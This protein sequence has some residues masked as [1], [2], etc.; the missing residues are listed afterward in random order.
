MEKRISLF[1]AILTLGFAQQIHAQDGSDNAD[2]SERW[3][4]FLP[5]NKE[6]AG[7]AELPLP[8]GIGITGYWQE[9]DLKPKSIGLGV[10]LDAT[11]SGLVLA[12]TITN[13]QRDG[14]ET[15]IGGGTPTSTVNTT[16]TANNVESEVDNFNVRL[17][18]WLFPFLNVYGLVGKVEGENTVSGVVVND[19]WT[20]LGAGATLVQAILDPLKAGVDAN[21]FKINY[22]GDV[23]GF[24]AILAGQW[25]KYWGTID[26]NFTQA[27][28][29]ITT[30]E[31]DT[32]TITPRIGR[33]ASLGN[34]KGALW[35]GAMHQKVDEDHNGKLDYSGINIEYK[36][37]NEQENEWNFL[38]GAAAELSDRIHVGIEGG[39]GERKQVMGN[40]TFRF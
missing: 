5:L 16:A 4:D 8:F 28:L 38:L 30:S 35:I 40:L 37:R 12:G 17:D 32:H 19:N 9:Q 31:I 36:V 27:D 29:D 18:A 3:S 7:D 20:A 15:L 26:Y 14:I 1:L 10:D 39:F 33:T 13:I 22:E 21:G 23:Y 2:D 34:V 25:G 11:L 24:G 6:L